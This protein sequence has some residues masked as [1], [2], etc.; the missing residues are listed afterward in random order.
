MRVFLGGQ[1]FQGGSV[2]GL[3]VGT[4]NRPRLIQPPPF[5]F[6]TLRDQDSNESKCEKQVETRH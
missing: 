6:D 4:S 5:T 3:G 2:G 1:R